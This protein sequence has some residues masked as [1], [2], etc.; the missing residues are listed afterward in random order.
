[1]W[2]NQTRPWRVVPLAMFAVAMTVAFTGIAGRAFRDLNG[3]STPAE[4]I[5]GQV[6]SIF[7]R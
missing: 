3:H 6:H 4:I 2:T 7:Q 1:M 5:A